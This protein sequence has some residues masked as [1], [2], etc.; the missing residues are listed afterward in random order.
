MRSPLPILFLILQRQ[1]MRSRPLVKQL[2]PNPKPNLERKPLLVRQPRLVHSL[3]LRRR[4]LSLR[5]A[6]GSSK[7]ARTVGTDVFNLVSIQDK[8]GNK[9]AWNY[10]DRDSGF[11]ASW[12]TAAVAAQS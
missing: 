3:R 11:S 9:D 5:S 6:L 1:L 12:G 4:L 7:L 2:H 8:E 10:I